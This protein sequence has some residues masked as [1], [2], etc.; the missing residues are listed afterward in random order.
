MSGYRAEPD[1]M[2]AFARRLEEVSGELGEAARLTDGVA[3][4][5]LGT[6]GIASA[7]DAV[8]RPWSDSIGSA[9]TGL[10]AAAAGI[11]TAAKTYEDTDE[12][13]VRSLRRFG[14]P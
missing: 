5:D 1:L 6:T 13:A 4:G 14:S 9:H 7:L 11:R 3:A 8:I 2:R 10:T 12:D